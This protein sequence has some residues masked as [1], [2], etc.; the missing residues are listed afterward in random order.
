M[1]KRMTQASK[2]ANKTSKQASSMI[3]LEVIPA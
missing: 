1:S 2:Q 3:K